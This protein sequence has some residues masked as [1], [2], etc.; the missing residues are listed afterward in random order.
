MN[1]EQGDYNAK[2]RRDS[3]SNL[4]RCNWLTMKRRTT[5]VEEKASIKPSFDVTKYNC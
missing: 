2:K 3:H 5:V 4:V 1:S